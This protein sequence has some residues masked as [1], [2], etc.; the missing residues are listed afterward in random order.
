M[1]ASVNKTTIFINTFCWTANCDRFNK[2]KLSCILGDNCVL[3]PLPLMFGQCLKKIFFYS[4]DCHLP[5]L[6][7][8][9]KK[10]YTS[11]KLFI[12]VLVLNSWA[13]LHSAFLFYSWF[14]F[15]RVW[16]YQIQFIKSQDL[17]SSTSR[18]EPSVA[19]CFFACE[20]EDWFS[21]SVSVRQ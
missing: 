11:T 14:L 10:V 19:I 13:P 21:A 8:Q 1:T 2:W 15:M 16:K 7:R 4:S 5:F 18:L 12:F 20:A 9:G 17:L 6:N 3:W